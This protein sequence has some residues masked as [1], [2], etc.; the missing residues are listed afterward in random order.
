MH[1]INILF[2]GTILFFLSDTAGW[3]LYIETTGSLKLTSFDSITTT[4]EGTRITLT[5]TSEL[6]SILINHHRSAQSYTYQTVDKTYDYSIR[7]E[8]NTLLAAGTVK[9][10]A[11]TNTFKIDDAPWYQAIEYSLG[12][13]AANTNLQTLDFWMVEPFN[14]YTIKLRA[15]K[16]NKTQIRVNGQIQDCL[17]VRVYLANFPPLLWSASYYFRPGDFRLLRSDVPRKGPGSPVTIL[18]WLGD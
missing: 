12:L 8:G 18:E 11:Y 2:L 5:N 15:R 1:L 9:K 13:F 17:L 14:L 10:A 3:G 16:E 6:H 4:P 7:R